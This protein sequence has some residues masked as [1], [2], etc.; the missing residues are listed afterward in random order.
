MQNYLELAQEQIARG[1]SISLVKESLK[2]HYQQ[3]NEKAY[4]NA[5]MVEYD[6]LYKINP[7]IESIDEVETTIGYEYTEDC[8]TFEEY[9]N[10]TR[11][12][13]AEVLDEEGIV[14]TP[15]VTELVRPYIQLTDDVLLAK[16][17]EYI[18][19]RYAEFREREY[20]DWKEFAD[21]W[22]KNDVDAMEEYRTKCLAVKAK[23]PK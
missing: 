23:Y 1:K 4:Y 6:A 21:A 17:D 15:E 12:V 14:I 11:V 5:M 2:K 22:V 9:K 8:P 3:E 7:I 16:A 19:S 13:T 20:P 10:E 18:S